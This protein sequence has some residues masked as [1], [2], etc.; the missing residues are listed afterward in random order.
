MGGTLEELGDDELE[1]PPVQQAKD[2]VRDATIGR[3]EETAKGVS[4]V[5]LE[6]IKNNPIPAAMAGAGLALLWM[7]RS[8]G[9]N[10]YRSSGYRA[11]GHDGRRRY[12]VT[13]A[14]AR[15]SVMSPVR[16]ATRLAAR[17][18]P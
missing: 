12:P 7:N 8:D 9:H 18:A 5:V 14:S 1:T 16:W 17:S 6:T 10:G 2:N 3:V 4:D 13:Q 15:R 11:D